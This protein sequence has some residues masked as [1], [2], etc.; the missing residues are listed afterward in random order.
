MKC[1][2]LVF[3]LAALANPGR[4]QAQ[5]SSTQTQIVGTWKLVS[6][7]REELPSGA[8]S[9]VLG[10][11]PSGYIN[12]GNDGRMMVIIVSSGRHKPT[13]PV[14]TPAEAEELLTSMLAYTGTY[15]IDS[16]AKTVTHHVDVSWDQTRTGE[17]HVRTFELN[18]DRLTLTTQPSRDPASGKTTIRTLVWEKVK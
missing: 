6:Y 9:Y 18:G 15:T 16:A 2:V 14:A 11:R 10:A 7:E 13:G 17:S 8:K 5:A 4:A 12:Y 1:C 3:L